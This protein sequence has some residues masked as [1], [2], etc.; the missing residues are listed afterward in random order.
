MQTATAQTD[1]GNINLIDNPQRGKRIT[2]D[3]VN[4]IP[5]TVKADGE[6]LT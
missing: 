3:E 4:T 5:S 6:T 2:A 1:T